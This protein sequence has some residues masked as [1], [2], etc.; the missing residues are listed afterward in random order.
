[1]IKQVFLENLDSPDRFSPLGEYLL[2]EIRAEPIAW[3]VMLVGFGVAARRWW[4]GSRRRDATETLLLV[5]GLWFGVTYLFLMAS[6][7]NQSALPFIAVLSVFGGRLLATGA[8]YLD[9]VSSRVKRIAGT[10]CL[11]LIVS[12]IPLGSAWSILPEDPPFRRMNAPYLRTIQYVLSLT[13]PGDAV[14]D[15]DTA[16]IFR[17]QA[18]YYGNLI[19][20]ILLRIQRGELDFDI[21]ERCERL[22]CKVI[23]AD[24][25]V[26]LLPESVQAWIRNNYIRSP[27]FPHVLLHRSLV[28]HTWSPDSRGS[29]PS[30]HPSSPPSP[31]EGRRGN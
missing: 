14:F 30:A 9:G 23:I 12:W 31:L 10:I 28:S 27:A 13:G 3:V 29:K 1:M 15:G 16:Y 5:A 8:A 11:V 2:R 7:Y 6:P 20:A 19:K 18:S 25:R 21:P 17:P 22:G 26:A 24:P 4:V